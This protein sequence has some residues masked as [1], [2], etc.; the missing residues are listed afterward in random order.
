MKQVDKVR[1]GYDLV[2]SKY[3][4]ERDHQSS[5]PYLE[6]LNDTLA[7]NSLILDLGCGAGLPV[8]QWLINAGHRVIGIDI[9]QS[10]LDLARDNV[11][12]ATYQIG[13]LLDLKPF[14]MSVDAVVCFFA[15]FH[16]D[17]TAHRR[18]FEV[19]RT[20]LGDRGSLLITTGRFDWEGTE[21][22]LGVEME[23]SHFDRAT[24]RQMIEECGF[25]IVME[26]EHRGNAFNDDDWHPIFLARSA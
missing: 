9:S 1:A 2:A 23:W 26:T 21:D 20:Y 22:F 6:R 8:D 24:Y 19:V 7:P 13:N 12:R 11:P 14:E 18:F 3:A 25:S 5:I 4:N 10:M 17:R 16:I 15:L